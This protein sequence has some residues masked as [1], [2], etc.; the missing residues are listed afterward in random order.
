MSKKHKKQDREQAETSLMTKECEPMIVRKYMHPG[1]FPMY[2]GLICGAN[3]DDLDKVVLEFMED[4]IERVRNNSIQDK[5]NVAGEL[6][7]LLCKTYKRKTEGVAVLW[8]VDKMFISSLWGDFMVHAPCKA[9]LYAI[10]N[11][12]PHI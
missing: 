2:V 6:T 8:Y 9:E 12:L 3:L 1:G 5:R 7:E 10:V 4:N 11:T